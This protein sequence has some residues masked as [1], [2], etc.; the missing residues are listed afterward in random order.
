LK[1]HK[2]IFSFLLFYLNFFYQKI[3]ALQVVKGFYLSIRGKI[4]GSGNSKKKKILLTE[5]FYN[6]SNNALKISYSRNFIRTFTGT[7][8]LV[9]YLV[10]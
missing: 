8:G 5:G 9:F 1:K 3:N 6:L 7:L 2:L 10:F 4:S